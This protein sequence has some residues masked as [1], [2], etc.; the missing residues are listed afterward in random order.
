MVVCDFN[1]VGIGPGLGETN[2]PLVVDADAVLPGAA[3]LQGLK[4]VARRKAEEGEFDGGIDQLE[5]GEGTGL[6]IRWQT[7][8]AGALPEPFSLRVGEALDHDANLPG[9]D[10]PSSG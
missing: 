2:A 1:L 5:L 6:N 7:T 4:P 9:H 8:R 3:T 10:Y